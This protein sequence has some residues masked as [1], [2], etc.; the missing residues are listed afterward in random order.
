[1]T[2]TNC[3]HNQSKSIATGKTDD[4]TTVA[5]LDRAEFET[6]I[7]QAHDLLVK[8]WIRRFVPAKLRE[9]IDTDQL[10]L[11]ILNDLIDAVGNRVNEV[12]IDE[13]EAIILC[14][15]ITKRRAIDSLRKSGRLKRNIRIE[16]IELGAVGEPSHEG[17]FGRP[18]RVAEFNDFLSAILVSLEPQKRRVL[19]LKRLEW[20]HCEIAN[21]LGITLRKLATVRKKIAD[22]T[23]R[24]IEQSNRPAINRLPSPLN[25]LPFVIN[26][27]QTTDNRRQT[28]DS[29]DQLISTNLKKFRFFWFNASAVSDL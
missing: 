9:S 11:E 21:E 15:T 7:Y 24:I 25:D 5:Q 3:E 22:A 18:D 28:T 23:R 2:Q 12:D 6:A 16:F 19:E 26:R 14:W 17:D 8:C 13:D 1:M 29:L 4:L 20:T 27:Q 10:K